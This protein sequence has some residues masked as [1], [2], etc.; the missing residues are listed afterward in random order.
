[1]ALPAELLEFVDEA[2]PRRDPVEELEEQRAESDLGCRLIAGVL[3]SADQVLAPT[4]RRAVGVREPVR[5]DHWVVGPWRRITPHATHERVL[6]FASEAPV[7][8]E[9]WRGRQAAAPA[10]ADLARTL[11]RSV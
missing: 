8:V 11:C 5:C 2:L 10:Q 6:A 9:H 1:K 7:R 3:H 4:I